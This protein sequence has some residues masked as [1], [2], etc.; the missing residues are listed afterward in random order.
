MQKSSNCE[1][2]NEGMH[3][4]VGFAFKKPLNHKI[5]GTFYRFIDNQ[6]WPR[7]MRGLAP[8]LR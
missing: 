8:S 3:R 6:E 1:N 4:I 7:I 5:L 2:E